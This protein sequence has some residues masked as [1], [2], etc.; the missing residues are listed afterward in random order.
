VVRPTQWYDELHPNTAGFTRV[1]DR[2]RER[3]LALHPMIV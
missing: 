3:I 2:F 1:R